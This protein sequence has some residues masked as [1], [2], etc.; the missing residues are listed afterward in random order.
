M[1]ED[2]YR[3]T[4]TL[5]I[6]W[7]LIGAQARSQASYRI[8]FVLDLVSNVL[9]LGADLAAILVIFNQVPALAGFSLSETMVIFGLGA[10]AFVLADLMVGNIERIKQY[11]RTGL[12]DAILVR[13]LGT[14]GQLL[15][16]DV[17][18]RRLGRLIYSL[19]ILVAA[20]HYADVQW[21]PARLLLALI[22][23]VA[24][25]VFFAAYFVAT[26]T[27]AF[28]WVES[29]DLAN[30]LTYGGRDFVSYPIN[31]FDGW[32]RR[33]VAF[34]LGFGFV[35]YYPA[36]GLLGRPDPLGGPGWLAWCGPLVSAVAAA[37]AALIWRTAVR[38]YRST[39][40]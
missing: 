9:F 27:V 10:T 20:T 13:P 37:A 34:G 5:R 14:L 39:G 4:D 1:A 2:G 12:L 18:Y 6:Y 21:T 36:L 11:V 30:A 31:V 16:M 40:S 35:S 26:A 25:A 33:V 3:T 7:R 38:H 15:A 32:F 24:G 22:T 17:G 29:G 23:P 28:W 8:S 19:A